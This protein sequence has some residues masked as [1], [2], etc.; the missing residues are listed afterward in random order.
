MGSV[1][2]VETD[3][4]TL[5]VDAIANAAN[6]DLRHGGGV[7]AAIARGAGAELERR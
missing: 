3:I 6:T 2:G 5:D 7:A 4:T 1:E